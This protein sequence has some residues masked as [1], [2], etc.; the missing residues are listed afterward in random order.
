MQTRCDSTGRPPE[1]F[2]LVLCLDYLKQ[3]VQA[4]HFPETSYKQMPKI[5]CS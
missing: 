4:Q 5:A 2:S 3:S 1:A